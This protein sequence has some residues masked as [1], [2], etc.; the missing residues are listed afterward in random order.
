MIAL[1]RRIA[2]C[3]LVGLSAPGLCGSSQATDKEV[4]L[5]S[6]CYTLRLSVWDKLDNKPFTAK[7]TV[8]S[9]GGRV[10]SVERTATDYNSSEVAFPNDFKDEKLGIAASLNCF[11]G[12]RYDW[13]IHAN[14]VLRDKG[15]IE[16]RRKK[17]VVGRE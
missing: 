14:G 4:W 7:Y 5:T 9:K 16:F 6:A 12:D 17:V 15:F 11:E 8:T 2:W 1:R 3:L 10:F 13:A